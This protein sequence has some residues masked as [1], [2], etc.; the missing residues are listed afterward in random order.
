MS[1]S[2]Q[3]S[4]LPCLAFPGRPAGPAPLLSPPPGSAGRAHAAGRRPGLTVPDSPEPV[5]P[6]GSPLPRARFRAL[7][8]AGRPGPAPGPRW[9]LRLPA[10]S[11]SLRDGPS[12]PQTRPSPPGLWLR[13]RNSGGPGKGTG[14]GGTRRSDGHAGKP[15]NVSC[16]GGP[17][18]TPCVVP[19]HPVGTVYDG[20]GSFPMWRVNTPMA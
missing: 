9:L 18:L 16:A 4:F 13:S 7:L 2:R 11:E 5:G 20:V 8:A 15:A 6:P 1:P 3:V 10:R 14:D 17:P 12:C 19:C